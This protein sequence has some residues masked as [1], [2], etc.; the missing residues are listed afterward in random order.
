MA[1]CR[2]ALIRGINVGRAKRVAM[3]DLRALLQELGFGDV[4]TLLNSGNAVF[5]CTRGTAAAAAKQI[6]KGL[7]SRIGVPARVL[8]LDADD[9]DAVIEENPL[10]GV[11]S[12]PT[13]LF[14]AVFM[15]SDAR[16]RVAPLARQKWGA[17]RLAVG[18]KAAYLW[19]PGGLAES[20]LTEAVNRALKDS[21]TVRNWATMSRLHTATADRRK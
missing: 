18:S 10:V 4:G 6:E 13:R 14:A 3:A 1:Q 8:V 11:A 19:C 21:V 16:A 20:P 12:D 9:L 5:T 15:D 2:V 17:E 7:A